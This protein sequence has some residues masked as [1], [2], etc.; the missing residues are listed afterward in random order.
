MPTANELI[1]SAALKLG[2]KDSGEALTPDESTDSLAILNSMLDNMALK[3]LMVYQIV[4]NSYT[5][6]ALA[7]SRTIGT[8]GNFNATRPIRIEDGTYFEDSNSQNYQVNIIRNRSTYDAI[9]TKTATSTYPDYLFYDPAYPLGVLNVYP[10][11]DVALTL[12]LNSWQTL[13]SFA[14]LTTDLSLPPG[15]RWM[16]EHNLAVALEAVFSFPAPPHVV[17]EAKSSRSDIMRV[18]HI[19]VTATTEA[20]SVLNGGSAGNIK[21]GG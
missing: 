14:S 11:P 7:S 13:Q 18:N 10:V 9:T 3:K 2:A 12:K 17:S 16:I 8:S 5:W 20:Y 6:P 1:E 19:P 21:A 4:Q 15:Y